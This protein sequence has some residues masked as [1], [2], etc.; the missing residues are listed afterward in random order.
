MILH[1]RVWYDHVE[2][3]VG[4]ELKCFALF[5][6]P[7]FDALNNLQMPLQEIHIFLH[8]IAIVRNYI[9]ACITFYMV[10]PKK[11]APFTYFVTF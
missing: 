11:S 4:V 5:W 2:F 10:V 8:Q 9:L 3:R 7:L 1:D 6:F